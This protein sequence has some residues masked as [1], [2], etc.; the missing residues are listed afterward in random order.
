MKEVVE[1]GFTIDDFSKKNEPLNQIDIDLLHETV[2][3]ITTDFFAAT[4]VLGDEL[5]IGRFIAGPFKSGGIH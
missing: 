4:M 5:L 1:L 2:M 3:D